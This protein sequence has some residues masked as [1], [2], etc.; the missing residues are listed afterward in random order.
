MPQ[1]GH[2]ILTLET[3]NFSRPHRFGSS[4]LGLVN[5]SAHYRFRSGAA[6]SSLLAGS[7]ANAGDID[8]RDK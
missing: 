1:P 5:F 6:C 4:A 7:A 2:R 8:R 3:F